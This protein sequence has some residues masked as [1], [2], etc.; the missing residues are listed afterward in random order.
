MVIIV[1]REDLLQLLEDDI[2]A[3]MQVDGGPNLNAF[4]FDPN[5]VDREMLSAMGYYDNRDAWIA[6][7]RVKKIQEYIDTVLANPVLGAQNP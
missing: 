5:L 2:K 7:V 4:E 6:G 3:W 1:K